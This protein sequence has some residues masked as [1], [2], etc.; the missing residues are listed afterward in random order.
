MRKITVYPDRTVRKKDSWNWRVEEPSKKKGGGVN[1][2]YSGHGYDTKA[3][4][5]RQAARHNKTLCEPLKV[6]V[7]QPN[8]KP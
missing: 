5:R 7:I 6:E 3:I 1:V 8:K 4:A 2:L